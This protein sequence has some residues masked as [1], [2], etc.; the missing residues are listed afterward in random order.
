M[1]LLKN[2]HKATLSEYDLPV[3]EDMNCLPTIYW[4]P[5]MHKT[6]VGE[7]LQSVV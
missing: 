5:K 2:S 3:K 1:N 6:P 4:I 7:L